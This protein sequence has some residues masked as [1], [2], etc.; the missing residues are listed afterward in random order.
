LRNKEL[1]A[2]LGLTE[3]E[4]SMIHS[5]T[6]LGYTDINRLLNG[7]LP[8]WKLEESGNIIKNTA[9]VLSQALAKLP[10]KKGL[11]VRRAKLPDAVLAEY[12]IGET[13]THTAFTSATF[14]DE[15]VFRDMPVRLKIFSKTGKR[16]DFYSIKEDELEV[17]FDKGVRFK[18][19]NR[20]EKLLNNL[21]IT[22][23]TLEEI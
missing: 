17:L 11:F 8:D 10:N 22:E 4:H 15:D 14:G 20:E 23:I 13:V 5:Y 18:V 2:S 19:M 16:I 7:T 3:A 1:A 12:Q 9:E 21:K 6:A